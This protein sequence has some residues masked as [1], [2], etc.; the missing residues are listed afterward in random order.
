MENKTQNL[1]EQIEQY[2][3]TKKF[4]REESEQAPIFKLQRLIMQPGPTMVMNGQQMKVPDQEIIHT[5]TVEFFGPGSLDE[6][7]EHEDHFEIIRFKV[8]D[9]TDGG[10]SSQEAEHMEGFYEDS[11]ELIRFK[12]MLERFIG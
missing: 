8:E 10:K 1:L 9:L 2:L 3:K 5:V 4:V 12:E 6:G 7:T 11:K